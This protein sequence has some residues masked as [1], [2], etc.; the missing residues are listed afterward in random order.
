MISSLL[1]QRDRRALV[2][3]AVVLL[4]ALLYAYAGRPYARA[5]AEA[6][7]DLVAERDL[8]VR[9]STLLSLADTLPA[10][11]RQ[12]AARQER[13]DARLFG[14]VD[15]LSALAFER[16]LLDRAEESRVHVEQS[17]VTLD[18]NAPGEFASIRA[19]LRGMSDL[20]GV[21]DWLYTLENG[22]RL[23]QVERIALEPIPARASSSEGHVAVTITAVGYALPVPEVPE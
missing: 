7:A 15:D 3:G 10:L 11:G 6:R 12:A 22:G 1:S 18:E 4:P 2:L 9:E 20:E 8:L 14:D 21:M 13:M 23:V 5:L 17:H 19:D 16:Y